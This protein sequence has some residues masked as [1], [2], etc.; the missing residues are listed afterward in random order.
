MSDLGHIAHFE[1]VW[2]LANIASAGAG[3]EGLDRRACLGLAADTELLR[4]GF[5]HRMVLQREYQHN[6]TILQTLQT[7]TGHPF[8]GPDLR[9]PEVGAR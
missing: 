5:V 3:S 7:E 6:E 2:L 4:D 8:P 9:R 1:E